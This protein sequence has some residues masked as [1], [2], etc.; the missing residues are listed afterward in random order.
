MQATPS[1]LIV[2]WQLSLAVTAGALL[3]GL[4]L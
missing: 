4:L 2:L 3:A 1:W